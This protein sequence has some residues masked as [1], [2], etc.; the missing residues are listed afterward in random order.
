[1]TRD[2]RGFTLIEVLISLFILSG[3]ILMVS[4]AWSGNFLKARKA[5]IFYD[6]STLLERKMAEVEAQFRDKFTE[7]P[8]EAG[9]AFEDVKNYRWT[10]KSRAMKFPDLAPLLAANPDGG[11]VDETLLGMIRQ[12]TEYLNKTIKEVRITIHVKTRAAKKEQEFSATQ[13]FIDYSQDFAAAAA[14]GA[15]GGGAAGGQSGGGK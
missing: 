13:Y 9:D 10:L 3:G 5:T 11:G 15:A 1:M 2:R 6:V 12:M 14:A 4:L 7:I 8:E